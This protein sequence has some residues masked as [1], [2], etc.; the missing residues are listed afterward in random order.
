M[1]C[2]VSYCC[3]RGLQIRAIDSED[4]AVPL[5]YLEGLGADGLEGGLGGLLPLPG[6]DGFPV[7]LGPLG[8]L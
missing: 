4:T 8:G 6:P 7:V 2:I 5:I 3:G 1:I